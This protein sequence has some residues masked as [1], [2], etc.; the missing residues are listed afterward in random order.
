[1]NFFEKLIHRFKPLPYER[2]KQIAKD[3]N[4]SERLT[5][6]KSTKTNREILFYLAEHDPM[7]EVRQRVATN[8][9]TPAQA[10]ELLARDAHADVRLALSGRLIKLLP[11]LSVDK[12]SQ[13]YAFTVQALG[14]LA[15]DEVLKVR[16]ALSA[17]LKD[18]AYAP[19]DVATAL[20]KDIER[21]VSEPILRFCAALS[22]EI[23]SDIIATHPATWAAEAIAQRPKI[24]AKVAKQIIQKENKQAGSFLIVN[25]GAE[26]DD[27][28]LQEIVD[29]AAEFPEWHEPLATHHVLPK[30]MANQ[31]ARYTDARIRTMLQD[32]GGYEVDEA[33]SVLDATRRRI[34]LQEN[35]QN[36]T[37]KD[38]KRSI[39]DLDRRGEL[40]E[41]MMGDYFAIG[42]IGFLYEALAYKLN[43]T[44]SK[45]RN[46]VGTKKAGVICA[47]C[48]K[49]DLSAR[50]AFRLQQEL[51]GIKPGELLVPKGGSEYPLSVKDMKWHLEFLEINKS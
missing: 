48:W 40:D 41:Q 32:K 21:E 47:I 42:D 28:V 26:I 11:A 36:R 4:Q 37:L 30:K 17:S 3:G 22:D 33:D 35:S 10:S 38:L 29:R 39:K 1:M 8:K 7:A 34:K 31:L 12:Q 45:I 20:A 44:E 50:F 14:T 49:A 27:S 25:M 18:Y 51:A 43:T 16:R 46:A 23:L 9:A 24:S 5:L 13:L 2:Q 15:L 19:P 6:A